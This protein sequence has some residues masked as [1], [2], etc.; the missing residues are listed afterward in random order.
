MT[1][2]LTTALFLSIFSLLKANEF[3]KMKKHLDN[4]KPSNQ[5]ELA[6]NLGAK[7][8]L[9]HSQE[10]YVE[11][12]KYYSQSLEIR[13]KLGMD[14]TN[15]YANIL[16]LSAIADSKIGNYCSAAEKAEEVVQIYTHLGNE[17]E[18]RLANKEGLMLFKKSC[19]E[20]LI[21]SNSL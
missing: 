4:A 1:K 15:G 16:L 18:A 14:R 17:D 12:I 11:A 19:Q 20:K 3:E 6:L 8:S 13:K 7:G 10:N 21:S 2:I 5:T 9:Y